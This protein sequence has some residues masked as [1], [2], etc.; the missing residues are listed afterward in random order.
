MLAYEVVR[1]ANLL[2]G[3]G[4][5]SESIGNYGT[6]IQISFV[7]TDKDVVEWVARMFGRKCLPRPHAGPW[8]KKE[9]WR[10]VLHGAAAADLMMLVYP[11]VS[12]RR[13]ARIVEVLHAWHSRKTK[14]R[15]R[16]VS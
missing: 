14:S 2:D 10:T 3:E 13:K 11:Y 7:S 4:C 8:A 1:L 12:E 15:L 16:L 9:Q 5:F 6:K